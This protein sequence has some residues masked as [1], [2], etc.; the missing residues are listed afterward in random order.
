MKNRAVFTVLFF[1]VV[2]VAVVIRGGR[3]DLRPM[4][5]DEANQAV[6][7]GLLLEK[8]EYTYDPV[9]HHGPTLYYLTLP[10]AWISSGTSFENLSE[11]TLRLVPVL[12]G[13]AI[14]L[15]L[16]VFKSGMSKSAKIFA[17]LIYAVSP[18][19]VFF[20]RFYIQEILLLFFMTG[21]IAS[22]WRYY[23]KPSSSWAVVTGLFVGLMY[24]TKETCVILFGAMAGALAL[25]FFI[26]RDIVET[27]LNPGLEDIIIL[28]VLVLLRTLLAF[29]IDYEIRHIPKKQL[30]KVFK[31]N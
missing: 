1:L 23:K 4:H 5:H 24:A 30:H 3:L 10:F 6:K 11:S 25:E 16:L 20:S 29:F 31:K 22:G 7:F 13:I 26:A 27:L 18:V 21:A 28:V 14:L 9:D 15:L 8:G 19:M 17:G 12:F 2:L